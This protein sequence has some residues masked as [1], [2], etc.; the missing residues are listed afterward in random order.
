VR[1]VVR[2][3]SCAAILLLAAGAFAQEQPKD[4]DQPQVK[5]NILNVCTPSAEEQQEIRRALTA[6]P[7]PKFAPDFE[8][9]RGQATVP[10]APLASYVRIRHDF[11][12]SLPFVAAQ[13]SLSVDP[14]SMME[15]LV[16]RSREAKD[17]IQI[18]LE[19]TITGAQDPKSVLATDTPVNHIKLERFGKSSVALARCESVDQ[20]GYEPLF[21]QASEVMMRYREALAIKRIVP[22]ELTALGIKP[23]APAAPKGTTPNK[24]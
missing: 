17:V 19:D 1:N 22:R 2:T 13:Y 9:T 7:N 8:V 16:F 6:I 20:A 23:T 10:D 11:V 5:V 24:P 3:V 15:D 4:K 18:Q 21:R 14:K 12:S